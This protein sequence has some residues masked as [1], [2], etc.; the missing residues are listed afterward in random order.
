MQLVKFPLQIP[1]LSH[2]ILLSIQE[3]S[4]RAPL[5]YQL[6]PRPSLHCPKT[7]DHGRASRTF[8]RGRGRDQGLSWT[9]TSK[10]GLGQF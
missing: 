7:S 10:L 2:T 8:P 6:D 9:W 3:D 4:V 1:K 5:A